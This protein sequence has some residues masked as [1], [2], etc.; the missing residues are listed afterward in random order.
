MMQKEICVGIVGASASNGWAKVSHVP[1]SNGLP[2]LG[3]KKV[4][5]TM[6]I[7]DRTDVQDFAQLLSLVVKELL[8]S[9]HPE[10]AATM[11]QR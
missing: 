5:L 1:A 2:G 7:Y 10:R 4:N 9:W 6:D 11:S 8:P 3:H